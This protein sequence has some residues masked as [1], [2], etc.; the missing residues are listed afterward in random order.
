MHDGHRDRLRKKFIMN[1]TDSMEDHEILELALFYAIPRKNTNEIAHNLLKHFG[2]I[3]SVFDAPISSLKEVDG[4]GENAAVFI[5]L[6]S[7]LSRIYTERKYNSKQSILKLSEINDRLLKKFIGRNEEVVAI[8]LLDAK[9]KLV[10]DGVINKGTINGVDLYIRKIIELV[11][12]Y[13]AVSVA[14][15]H[16]HPSGVALPSADDIKST[17]RINN[18]LAGMQVK[19]LDHIIVADQDYVSMRESFI[20]SMFER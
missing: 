9:G 20:G 6:I 16:N 12:N 7:S 2:S 18:I 3:S 17:E 19:L 10:Y 1:D 4:I 14:I 11:V 13:N 5:K 15:S 8:A